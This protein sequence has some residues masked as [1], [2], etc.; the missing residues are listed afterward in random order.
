[1]KPPESHF[2]ITVR[3][4]LIKSAIL[5]LFIGA[6]S[7][8]TGNF[9]SANN[10]DESSGNEDEEADPPE[11]VTGAYLTCDDTNDAASDEVSYG[12]NLSKS[13]GKAI[14]L[15]DIASKWKWQAVPPAN[16][17]HKVKLIDRS[18][19]GDRAVFLFS[20]G[21]KTDLRRFAQDTQVGLSLS[22]KKDVPGYR[23]FR[24]KISD[25]SAPGALGQSSAGSG[26]GAAND[27]K[28]KLPEAS[29][30][31][32]TV[33]GG[34]EPIKL[35]ELPASIPDRDK[36]GVADSDDLCNDSPPGSTVWKDGEWR[37]CSGGE[38]K[39]VDDL[40][41]DHVSNTVD[42]CPSTPANMPVDLDPA[43]PTYGCGATEVIF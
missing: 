32:G 13:N 25:A 36:D 17:E 33:T 18:E 40:D 24:S 20:G 27:T 26:Q 12:C 2:V 1:M 31:S 19:D 21:G 28:L 22:L 10:T 5:S 7:G 4:N 29:P 30:A 8:G 11:V 9:G 38:Y 34:A 43:S 3:N 37:G 41:R 42:I 6:C 39:D 35:P 16:S 15:P 14:N 23:P